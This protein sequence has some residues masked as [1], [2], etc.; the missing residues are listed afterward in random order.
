M[1]VVSQVRLLTDMFQS[2][3]SMSRVKVGRF[4]LTD[5]LYVQFEVEQLLIPAFSVLI[6]KI[7]KF[8]LRRI[9]VDTD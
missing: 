9:F 7:C 4:P 1:E 8:S 2:I 3:V 5:S 6:W